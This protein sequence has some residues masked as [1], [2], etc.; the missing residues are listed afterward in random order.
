MV[1]WEATKELATS[2][3]VERPTLLIINYKITH[4]PDDKKH[5]ARMRLLEYLEW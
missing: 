4:F 5:L 3:D 1:K 2:E